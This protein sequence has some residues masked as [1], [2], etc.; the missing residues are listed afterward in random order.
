MN[1]QDNYS[2]EEVL[3]LT[4]QGIEI[5][6]RIVIDD[7]VFDY[8]VSNL[9]RIKSLRWN[10]SGEEIGYGSLRKD[11]GYMIKVLYYRDKN[12]NKKRKSY[13]IHRLV[14]IMF[15]PNPY[16]KP[17]IDHFDTN[18]V[19]NRVDNLNWV[20][21]QENLSNNKTKENMS[22]SQK[23]KTIRRLTD[24]EKYEY[25]T[26]EDILSEKWKDIIGYEGI[27]EISN[28]GRVKSLGFKRNEFSRYKKGLLQPY[29]NK[30]GYRTIKLTNKD[31]VKKTYFVHQLVAK[32]FIP[33]HKNKPYVDHISTNR[34]DNRYFNLR[35]TTQQENMNNDKTKENLSKTSIRPV[36]VLNRNGKIISN[37]LGVEETAKKI[38]VSISFLTKL[39]KTN[40]PYESKVN[41]G[42]SY[43]TDLLRLL[44]GIRVYYIDTYNEEE[45]LKEMTEDKTD[46]SCC[47]GDLI[48]IYTDDRISKPM[49]GIK[50]A[51]ELGI[52]KFTLNKIRDSKKP[53]KAPINSSGLSKE[54]FKHLKTLNGIRIMYYEDYLKEQN[55]QDN[56]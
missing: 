47:Q 21:P 52:S 55:Q 18:K 22:N 32:H 29:T 12:D 56:N 1:N 28:M 42:G 36:I 15:I 44:N 17:L 49:S 51:K 27:Y 34:A 7:I 4:K 5:W 46:Y 23:G 41:N 3:E 16:N 20:T 2:Y 35:W 53:Y 19:N 6:R 33:N 48:C 26:E 45:V 37:G 30:Y 14:A 54:K 43:D 11:I 25:V 9:G 38:G 31:G 24:E 8:E 50:L 13:L 39:L 10:G 40:K